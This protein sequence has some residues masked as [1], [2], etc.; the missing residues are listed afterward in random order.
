MSKSADSCDRTTAEKEILSGEIPAKP[1]E[2]YVCKNCPFFGI[3]SFKQDE[4]EQQRDSGK[5]LSQADFIGI[6]NQN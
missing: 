5:E 6:L 2:G 4:R 3:C 1:I